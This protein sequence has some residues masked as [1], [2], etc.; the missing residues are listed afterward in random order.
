MVERSRRGI[1]QTRGSRET[2]FELRTTILLVCRI[3][4]LYRQP[5]PKESR[6]WGP[7][8]ASPPVLP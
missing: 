1:K 8:R 6:P 5:Q 4:Y 7:T 2:C 3:I